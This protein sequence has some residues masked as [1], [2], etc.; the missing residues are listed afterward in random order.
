MAWLCLGYLDRFPPAAGLALTGWARGR[1]L[2]WVVHD[3]TFGRRGLPGRQPARLLEETTAGLR[4]LNGTAGDG[5]QRA[6]AARVADRLASLGTPAPAPHAVLVLFAG[7]PAGSGGSA[8]PVVR[9]IL[10]GGAGPGRLVDTAGI[11]VCVVD[12]GLR[13]DLP[14]VPGLAPRR[15]PDRPA[16]LTRQ[17]VVR[18]METGIEIARDYYASGNGWLLG[19]VLTGDDDLASAISAR[20]MDDATD[21]LEVL[22]ACDGIE[23]AALAGFIVGARTLRAPVVLRGPGAAAATLVA[24]TLAPACVAACFPVGRPP[25][26]APDPFGHLGLPVLLPDLSGDLADAAAVALP[27]LRAAAEDAHPTES[28]TTGSGT[29]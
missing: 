28:V 24:S 27:F 13:D 6:P 3:E 23:V 12:L 26:G 17:H 4:S 21:P 5:E 25:A 8:G 14:S 20:L 7:D 22:A 19:D 18:A 11:E 16:G 1:P 15:I 10:A 2:E 29:R 9:E